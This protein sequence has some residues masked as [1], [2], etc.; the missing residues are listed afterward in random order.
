MGQSPSMVQK[1]LKGCVVKVVDSRP[2][3]DYD[4]AAPLEICLQRLGAEV[5]TRK[6]ANLTHVVIVQ[7]HGDNENERVVSSACQAARKVRD[8]VCMGLTPWKCCVSGVPVIVQ[9]ARFAT[10][11]APRES[12]SACVVLQAAAEGCKVVSQLWVVECDRLGVRVQVRTH[13]LYELKH[14]HSGKVAVT[15]IGR[16]IIFVYGSCFPLRQL[17]SCKTSSNRCD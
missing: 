3:S 1:P 7:R 9:F 4:A 17:P 5:T 6:S 8:R 13:A 10:L 15:D 14:G 2:G 12:A 11:C 16:S